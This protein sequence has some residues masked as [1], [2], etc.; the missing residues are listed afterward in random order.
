[1]SPL[2]L[3]IIGRILLSGLG[4]GVLLSC[5]GSGGDWTALTTPPD[6]ERIRRDSAEAVETTMGLV[7]D[8]ALDAAATRSLASPIT[9]PRRRRCGY[10]G[11]NGKR[12]AHSRFSRILTCWL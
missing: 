1:M 5:S 10:G 8:E 3:P 7:G 11:V 12:M 2:A 4:M 9:L 6:N